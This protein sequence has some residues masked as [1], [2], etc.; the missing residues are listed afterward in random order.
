MPLR[1][2]LPLV[3]VFLLVEQPRQRLSHWSQALAPLDDA[4][5]PPLATVDAYYDPASNQAIFGL[6]YDEQVLG[7]SIYLSE[8]YGFPAEKVRAALVYLNEGTEKVVGV[9]PLALDRFRAHF[10]SSVVQMR[11]LLADPGANLP[12]AE[13]S[14]EMTDKLEACQRC[15]FRRPCGR[16]A[17][18][19]HPPAVHPQLIAV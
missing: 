15:V 13:T 11:E 18:A 6:R 1:V 10:R 4:K 3:E 2:S 8:R 14:F 9:D 12:H 17:V 19:T 16:E 7:Y 5:A